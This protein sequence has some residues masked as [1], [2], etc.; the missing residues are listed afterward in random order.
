MKKKNDFAINLLYDIPIVLLIMGNLVYMHCSIAPVATLISN[1]FQ[2]YIPLSYL[3]IDTVVLILLCCLFSWN[4]RKATFISAFTFTLIWAI[5]NVVYS[6]FFYTYIQL[7][8]FGEAG[9]LDGLWTN[10]IPVAFRWSDFYFMVAIVLFTYFIKRKNSTKIHYGIFALALLICF[11]QIQCF[12]YFQNNLNLNIK[13]SFKSFERTLA[14]SRPSDINTKVLFSGI[15]YSQFL[16][17]IYSSLSN[18]ELNA[19]EEKSIEQYILKSQCHNTV[20]HANQGKNIELI[21]CESYLSQTSDLSING[22]EITPYLN[23]LRHQVGTY[24]NGNVK[25]NIQIGESA[26]GQLITLTGLLP[27][28]NEV[29]VAKLAKN[30]LFAFPNELKKLGY[31]TAMIIPTQRN[32]WH[33]EDACKAYGIDLLESVEG[34]SNLEND[35]TTLEKATKLTEK[36]NSPFLNCILTLSTHSPY[37]TLPDYVSP[38]DLDFPDSY[39][40]EYRNYLSECYYMDKAIEKHM[41]DLKVKG[42]YDNTIFIIVADH[43]AHAQLLNMQK[44]EVQN[45][46]IPFYI[47]NAKL[48]S[49]KMW[50]GT[51]NQMDIYPTLLDLFGIQSRW[52]GMGCSIMDR[53]SYKDKYTEEAKQISDLIIRSNYFEKS[54]NQ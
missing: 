40:K 18:Y 4:H 36:L 21:I 39:S 22:I 23:K 9:N 47:V 32:L 50:K 16:Y 38:L 29:T 27:L 37:E 13:E 3:F 48:D 33:Q 12:Y 24:Y 44:N 41:E 45:E 46:E 11:V 51:M 31:S 8:T 2:T 1:V 20:N 42:L 28:S 25:T 5:I 49:D 43:E 35:V 34:I 26:D 52:R 15:T 17:F 53:N 54:K 19:E 14:L 6:R 10:Y 30:K 7:S